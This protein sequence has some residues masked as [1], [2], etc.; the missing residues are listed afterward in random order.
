M[1][2]RGLSAIPGPVAPECALRSWFLAT[3]LCMALI[4]G[5]EGAWPG[6]AIAAAVLG[7][8]ILVR[9]AVWVTLDLNEPQR[10]LITVSQEPLERLLSGMGREVSV[11]TFRPDSAVTTWRSASFKAS[12]PPLPRFSA[13]VVGEGEPLASATPP[14]PPPASPRSTGKGRHTVVHSTGND[15]RWQWRWGHS[16]WTMGIEGFLLRD[17]NVPF[18]VTRLPGPVRPD[19]DVE[20]TE[21][22]SAS[23]FSLSPASGSWS[24]S[25]L[26]GIFSAEVI[27]PGNSRAASG[28]AAIKKAERV[29]SRL[30]IRKKYGRRRTA[31][32]TA[33]AKRYPRRSPNQVVLTVC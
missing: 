24:T 16:Q 9:V 17:L 26:H 33:T 29:S 4:G 8:V 31:K 10:G 6:S 28:P 32:G 21:L 15:G 7:F 13:K 20:R 19:E 5:Q 18:F 27:I 3:V 23:R 14:H 1:T 22:I 2:R 25:Y 30:T 12:P 11:L